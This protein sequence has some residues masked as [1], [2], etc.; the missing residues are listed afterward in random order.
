MNNYDSSN[1][2][3]TKPYWKSAIFLFHWYL[4]DQSKAYHYYLPDRTQVLYG[5]KIALCEYT[6]VAYSHIF[7]VKSDMVVEPKLTIPDIV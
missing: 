6:R 1:T 4:F 3:N 5:R 2:K 7:K